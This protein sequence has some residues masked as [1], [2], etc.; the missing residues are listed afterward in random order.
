MLSTK[1]AEEHSEF[2][3]GNVFFC[4]MKNLFVLAVPVSAEVLIV[5]R[6]VSNHN[7]LQR[8]SFMHVTTFFKFELHKLEI[9]VC[10]LL[11]TQNSEGAAQ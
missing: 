7:G 9:S 10:E 4:V 8:C 6:Q 11:D 5:T 3:I 1:I 2:S